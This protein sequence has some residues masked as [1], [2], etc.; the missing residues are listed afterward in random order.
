MLRDY[1]RVVRSLD[2]LDCRWYEY[3]GV[4]TIFTKVVDVLDFVWTHPANQGQRARAVFRA[5]VYQ[6]RARFLH[7]RTQT[8]LG[9]RSR[10]WVDLH[11]GAAIRAVYGNPPDY[12]E[13]LVW[14]ASLGPGD[15]FLDVGANIGGYSVWAGELGA[16]VISFEPAEDTY[17]ILVDNVALNGYPIRALQAA[18]G[19]RC[20]IAKFTTG[21][22]GL[23]RLDPEGATETKVVTID[24]LIGTRVVAG[25]KV[26]V[27]GFEI[28][29]LRGC[30]E[31]LQHHRIKLIQLEWNDESLRSLGM[32]R[33]PIAELLSKYGYGLYRPDVGGS[34]APITDLGFGRDVFAQPS[35]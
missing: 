23:N 3:A 30:V 8:R 18:A 33:R 7:Q 26:D 20:G 27:E 24:S 17:S 6:F 16:E 19:E 35:D 1:S 5:V 4:M 2:R 25:M 13:M 14:R 9:D 31:A 21:L 28:E 10:L 34:L 15:L 12:E 32:D 11:R 22:D 29:V